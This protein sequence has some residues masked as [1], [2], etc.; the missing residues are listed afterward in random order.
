MGKT[1]V[2]ALFGNIGSFGGSGSNHRGGGPTVGRG[3]KGQVSPYFF[4]F[5][6][7]CP[8]PTAWPSPLGPTY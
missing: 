7:L 4:S 6:L 8:G 1:W 2:N 3:D 5:E